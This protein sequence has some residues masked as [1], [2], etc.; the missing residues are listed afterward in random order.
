MAA[1]IAQR[2]WRQQTPAQSSTST[3]PQHQN[4]SFTQWAQRVGRRSDAAQN[5]LVCTSSTAAQLSQP[6][7]DSSSSAAGRTHCVDCSAQHSLSRRVAQPAGSH[8]RARPLFTS[9]TTTTTTTCII[10][11][12]ASRTP[13]PILLPFTSLPASPLLLSAEHRPT[14]ARCRLSASRATRTLRP[15]ACTLLLLSH[16]HSH[17]LPLAALP[18]ATLGSR[19]LLQI[20]PPFRQTCLLAS[21]ATHCSHH[22]FGL[23][24]CEFPRHH[25]PI[26][27]SRDFTFTSGYLC[28][29]LRRFTSQHPHLH[30]RH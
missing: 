28:F 18:V 25:H 17:A 5:I 8:D 19:A 4:A 26:P 27:V 15:P 7:A 10:T 11:T 30:A 3:A 6:A 12:A 13:Y 9:S 29:N 23:E 20:H 24:L 2:R 1:A 14:T 21:I 22:S 16:S